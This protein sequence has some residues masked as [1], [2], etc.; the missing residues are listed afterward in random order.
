M[1][2]QSPSLKS[3]FLLYCVGY[4]SRK[5]S[6]TSYLTFSAGRTCVANA[7]HLAGPERVHNTTSAMEVLP[8]DASALVICELRWAWRVIGDSCAATARCAGHGVCSCVCDAC[9]G[10]V[11]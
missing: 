1:P 10:Y 4:G 8:P 3:G 2:A 5:Y 7:V 6:L 11:V 9:N